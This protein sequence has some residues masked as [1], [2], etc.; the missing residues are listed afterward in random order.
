MTMGK[1]YKLSSLVLQQ[2][3]TGV[4]D[5]KG[6]YCSELVAAFLRHLGLLEDSKSHQNYFPGNFSLENE[7]TSV[8]LS[9]GASYSQEFLIDFNLSTSATAQD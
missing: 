4:E 3:G 9:N 7:K 5:K 2:R 6:W 1:E 8:K